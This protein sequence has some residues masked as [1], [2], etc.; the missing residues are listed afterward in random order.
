MDSASRPGISYPTYQQRHE[1]KRDDFIASIK[2]VGAPSALSALDSLDA[3]M[4]LLSLGKL[5]QSLFLLCQA[6]EVGLKA[7]LEEID[8]LLTQDQIEWALAKTLV[9][10]KIERHR[11]GRAITKYVDDGAYDPRRTCGLLEAHSRV[12]EMIELSPGKKR[13]EDLNKLRNQIAHHGGKSEQRPDYLDAVLNVAVPFL[14]HFYEKGYGLALADF[15]YQ[16]VRREL[17]IARTYL[18]QAKKGAGGDVAWALVT[19]SAAL[20]HAVVLG[21]GAQ[22]F[23]HEG[24]AIDVGDKWFEVVEGHF[25]AA[26]NKGWDV[27]G[28]GAFM[29]CVICGEEC[30]VGIGDRQPNAA[31]EVYE[32]EALDCPSC[33]LFIDPSHSELA[34]IH[35]GPITEERVGPQ[36]WQR[37]IPR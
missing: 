28:R 17:E 33:G 23:D 24:W 14:D 2:S 15:L 30:V 6:I 1:G 26:E 31:V 19:F 22:L 21:V 13:I 4:W 8:P 10:D 9:R 27:I 16:D 32:A 5:S 25:R 34:R 7:V 29:R 12:S 20:H 18:N 3:A 11:L 35:Y 36:A 37:E